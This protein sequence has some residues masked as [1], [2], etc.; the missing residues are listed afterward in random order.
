MQYFGYLR[1]DPDAEGYAFWL[2]KLN[3]FG[4]FIDAESASTFLLAAEYRARF[5]QP[6]ALRS[7]A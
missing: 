7:K 1:S 5:G 4:N 2:A 3:R 6:P